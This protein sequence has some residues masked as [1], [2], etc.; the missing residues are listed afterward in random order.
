MPNFSFALEPYVALY[1]MIVKKRK[2][3]FAMSDKRKAFGGKDDEK[4]KQYQREARLQYDPKLVNESHQNW[5][6]YTK[7]QQDFIKEEGSRIYNEIAEQI[8]AG[9]TATDKPV[10]DL[11]QDWH[12]HLRYFYEPTLPLLE[13]LGQLYNTS[14]EFV[15]NFE[16]I[17]PEL[18]AFLESAI[19]HYVD[20]LETAE[21]E[22]MLAEDEAIQ[23]REGKLSS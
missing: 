13:G 22:A 17:H 1:C 20:E 19:T 12:E 7:S 21:I 9:K 8:E 16:Q 10:Q 6:S 2:E 11:M 4:E 14:P 5:N 18:P 3:D 23:K 15:A